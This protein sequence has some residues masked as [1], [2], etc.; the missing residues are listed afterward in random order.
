[1]LWLFYLFLFSKK[2]YFEILRIFYIIYLIFGGFQGHHLTVNLVAHPSQE[3]DN[4]GKLIRQK[5]NWSHTKQSMRVDC[6][7]NKWQPLLYICTCLCIDTHRKR[8]GGGSTCYRHSTWKKDQKTL[9]GE[10]PLSL[11][12]KRTKPDILINKPTQGMADTP[13]ITQSN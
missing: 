7:P 12:L 5:P 9:A 8:R 1:M 3:T 2:V 11:L 13:Y 10:F 4:L 6:W